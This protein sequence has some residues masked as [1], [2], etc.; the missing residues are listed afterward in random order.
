MFYQGIVKYVASGDEISDIWIKCRRAG[1]NYD[2]FRTIT[3]PFMAI[4]DRVDFEM[5]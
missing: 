3:G 2:K 4:V 1:L 5:L